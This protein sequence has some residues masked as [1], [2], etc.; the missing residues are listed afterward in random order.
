MARNSP[1]Q[2]TRLLHRARDGD[3]VAAEQAASLVYDELHDLASGYMGNERPDHSLQTTVL[4][5]EAWAQLSEQP[6]AEWKTRAAFFAMAAKI[7]RHA[8]VNHALARSRKKRGGGREREP[9]E[10]VIKSLA[11]RSLAAAEFLDLHE[12]LDRFAQVDERAA[13][14]VELRFFSGLTILETAKVLELS[15]A[16]VESD[17]RVARAW[18]REALAARAGGSDGG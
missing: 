9:F 18:L 2:L 13:R 8:L 7:M 1:S 11:V 14:V 4:V 17:F 16:T 6:D 10:I 12:A 3:E 5:H 15:S